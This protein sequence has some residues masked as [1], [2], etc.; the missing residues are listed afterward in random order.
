MSTHT[1]PQAFRHIQMWSQVFHNVP[2]V[3]YWWGRFTNYIIR[4]FLFPFYISL[5]SPNFLSWYISL[6]HLTKTNAKSQYRIADDWNRFCDI[7]H[8][9]FLP[10][11]SPRLPPPSPG[12]AYLSVSWLEIVRLQGRCDVLFRHSAWLGAWCWCLQKCET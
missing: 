5:F 3:P 9:W 1:F 6:Y 12:L 11:A 2:C 7:I 10:S 8:S 4:H